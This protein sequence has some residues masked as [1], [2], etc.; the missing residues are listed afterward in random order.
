[1]NSLQ[2]QLW[3][4]IL[5]RITTTLSS[6]LIFFLALYLKRVLGFELG[7]I[8]F[9][10]TVSAACYVFGSLASSYFV[11]K[12]SNK[13]IIVIAVGIALLLLLAIYLAQSA[14]KYSIIALI[15]VYFFFIGMSYPAIN[16]SMVSCFSKQHA[17]KAAGIITI[18][19]NGS[20]VVLYF[21]G[22]ILLHALNA[23][24]LLPFILMAFLALL[25]ACF[26]Y[27]LSDQ[28]IVN[29]NRRDK[30]QSRENSHWWQVLNKMLIFIF[31]LYLLF[32]ILDSPRLFLLPNWLHMLAENNS[33][34]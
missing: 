16:S 19:Q 20:Y 3:L 24:V 13:T 33:A 32:S 30:H 14:D 26:L 22:G 17:I 12:L 7:F 4:L 28:S 27:L 34:R 5:L 21:C 31:I 9:S 6:F 15:S 10:V 2:K 11:T 25:F 29:V 8:S 18:L 23:Y 1:M